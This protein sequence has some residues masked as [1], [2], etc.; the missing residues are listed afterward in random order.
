MGALLVR[1]GMLDAQQA[2]AIEAVL[3]PPLKN[4]A[5]IAVGEVRAVPAA[6]Q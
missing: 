2:A 4:V 3:R 5:G 6:F 1:L